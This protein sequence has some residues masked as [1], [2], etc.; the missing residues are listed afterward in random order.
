MRDAF[1]STEAS[2]RTERPADECHNRRNHPRTAQQLAPSLASLPANLSRI[3]PKFAVEMPRRRILF[4]FRS[5]PV[6]VA[7]PASSFVG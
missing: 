6:E 4:S 7:W 2:P 5:S 3:L 1:R